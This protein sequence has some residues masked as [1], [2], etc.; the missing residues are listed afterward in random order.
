MIRSLCAASAL[1][2]LTAAAHSAPT[3]DFTDMPWGRVAYAPLATAPYPHPSRDEG[4]ATASTYFPRAGHYDDSTVAFL[5]PRGYRPGSEVDLVVHI[6]GWGNHVSQIVPF[7]E[8]GEQLEAS[9]V[10]AIMLV[11]QGPRDASDSRFG[12]LD[13][14]GGFEAF[15]REALDSLHRS[16]VTGT[17]RLGRIVI[18]G[19]SGGYYTLGQIIANGDLADH[20]AELWLFDSTYAQLEHFADFAQRPDTRVRSIFTDHLSDENVNFMCDLQKRGVPFLFKYDQLV[21]DDDLRDNR[22][23]FMHTD[24]RHNYVMQETHHL[25]RWLRTSTLPKR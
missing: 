25:E 19:H 10:N 9:G 2:W 12:K 24:L 8:L 14:P 11:P 16:G 23:V 17:E 13:E 20:I 4:Y 22:I 3:L 21:T 7:Y 1:V 15:I 18:M 5:V 6:H